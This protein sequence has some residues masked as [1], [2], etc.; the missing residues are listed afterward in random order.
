[1]EPDGTQRRWR[2]LERRAC[3]RDLRAAG[4]SKR[5]ARFLASRFL[6]EKL[7]ALS[8]TLKTPLGGQQ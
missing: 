3:E 2:A 8:A 5:E 7:A 1:M 4:H 6:S